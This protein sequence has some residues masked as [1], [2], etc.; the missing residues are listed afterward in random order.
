MRIGLDARTLTAEQRSG[1]EL[2]VV[3]LVRALSRL[4]G[5]PEIIAYVDRPIPDPELAKA[6]S[7]GPLRTK[8]V[9]ARRGWLRM[10]LPLQ[11]RRDGVDLVHLPSTIMP[12]ILPCPAV[13]TVHDLAWVKYPE[14]YEPA[15]LRMQQQAVPRSVRRAAHVI[16]VSETTARDVVEA[17]GAAREK[18][19]VTLL[20][21]SDRFSPEG[22][23][24]RGNEWPGAE[25]MSGGYLLY[26]GRL[27]RRKNLSRVLEAYHRLH[28]QM[29]A[30]PLV[31][32]GGTT[33]HSAELA[34]EAVALGIEQHVIF[35]GYVR[36]SLLPALYRS[37]LVFIYVSLYEGFGM[38][39]LEAMASGVATITSN[40]SGMAEAAGEAALQVDPA[41]LEELTEALVR[42]VGDEEQ[43]AELAARGPARS[44]EFSWERTAQE[45]VAAYRR[46]MEAK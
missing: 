38:P 6:A 45:T 21:V 7:S 36:E 15:D 27:Q 26:A 24:L 11:L 44:R 34:E 29:A 30:P 32:A 35:P 40:R 20:G 31:L 33:S 12:P 23:R 37:A 13:V 16:A 17:L 46:A 18:I 14:S 42:L 9:R 19:S 1:V 39:V 8:V 2:Y 25:R 43:R 4:E 3:E 28:G 10:A 5:A 22:P 41:S